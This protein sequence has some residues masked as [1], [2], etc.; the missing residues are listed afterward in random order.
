M[1]LLHNQM[2]VC[3]HVFLAAHTVCPILLRCD[4]CLQKEADVRVTLRASGRRRSSR[5]A[6]KDLKYEVANG[7]EIAHVCC[8]CV[9]GY[10]CA[11]VHVCAC[12]WLEEISCCVHHPLVACQQQDVDGVTERRREK[13]SE[14]KEVGRR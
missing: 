8:V 2:S 10:V 3:V 4:E 7:R 1:E 11:H 5:E 9:G 6:R 12:G 13:S 14:G